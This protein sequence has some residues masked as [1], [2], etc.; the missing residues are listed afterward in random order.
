MAKPPLINSS[1]LAPRMVPSAE[2]CLVTQTCPT[3]ATPWTVA[4]WAPLSMGISQE[5]MP[6]WI[7]IPF[8]RESSQPRDQTHISFIAGGFFTAEYRVG[9][10][11][12]GAENVIISRICFVLFILSPTTTTNSHLVRPSSASKDT[13]AAVGSHFPGPRTHSLVQS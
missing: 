4:R 13:W 9:T 1:I 8:S 7:A 3:L 10:Q 11:Y 5:R 12:M 2:C 6:E